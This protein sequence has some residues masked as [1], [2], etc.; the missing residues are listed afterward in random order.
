MIRDHNNNQKGKV[1]GFNVWNMEN[2]PKNIVTRIQNVMK[3]LEGEGA[4]IRK[5]DISKTKHIRDI[6]K[7]EFKYDMNQYL[8]IPEDY[9]IKTLSDI[10]E[11]N[12]RHPEKTLKYGQTYLV[13]AQE[14][15]SELDEDIYKSVLHTWERM[16]TSENNKVHIRHVS[17]SNIL[18][19]TAFTGF[20]N[21]TWL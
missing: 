16:A 13:D 14:N 9:P 5:V 6:M 10:I 1:I 11:F 8:I 2:M 21:P 15:T 4:V 12:E 20:N 7:Y 17:C 3:E 19:Y 18:Q